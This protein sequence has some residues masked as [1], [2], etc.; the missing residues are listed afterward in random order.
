MLSE[1]LNNICDRA[2][3]GSKPQMVEADPTKTYA[4]KEPDGKI[5]FF[6]GRTPYRNHQAQDLE[7]IAAFAERF[8]PD[9]SIWYSREGITLFVNDDERNDRVLVELLHTDQIHLLRKW[10]TTKPKLTQ[11]EFLLHLRTV[12][13]PAAFPSDPTLIDNLRKVKW[14]SGAKAEGEIQ[15]GRSSIGKAVAAEA[16]FLAHIPETVTVSVPIFANSFSPRSYPVTCALEIYEDSQ[17]LQMFPLPGQVERAYS[18]A[19]ADLCKSILDLLGEDSE[20]PVYFGV[21]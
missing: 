21:P 10:E 11:R 19:E 3:A 13:T 12:L 18:A 15:R 20:V 9:P 2:V 1:F 14:E 6:G 16:T 8:A 4:S 5:V 17:Q 7:T